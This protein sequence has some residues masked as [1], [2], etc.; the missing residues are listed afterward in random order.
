MPFVRVRDKNTGDKSSI[1]ERAVRDVHE[2]LD[3]PAVDLRGKPLRPEPK[4]SATKAAPASTP[5][6]TN[7]SEE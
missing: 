2:V 3:E 4:T 6:I 1:P 5:A 7:H